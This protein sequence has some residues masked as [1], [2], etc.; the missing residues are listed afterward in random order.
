MIDLISYILGMIF[1][2][3]G[4]IFL[5]WVISLPQDEMKFSLNKNG[6]N[7]TAYLDM[8]EWKECMKECPFYTVSKK[9]T[10]TKK[11]KKK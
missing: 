7:S 6:S 3:G 11:R 1:G 4:G 5:G 2:L 9:K 8:D 10:K